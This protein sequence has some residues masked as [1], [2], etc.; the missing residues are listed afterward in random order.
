VW[1]QNIN[2]ESQESW[3]NHL[4]DL[5][6]GL[7]SIHVSINPQEN[8]PLPSAFIYIRNNIIS[9]VVIYLSRDVSEYSIDDYCSS[10]HCHSNFVV[11][12]SG[13]N[14]AHQIDDHGEF[15]NMLSRLLKEQLL[16]RFSFYIT[17]YFKFERCSLS[18]LETSL[19]WL[20]L[21]H[22]LC[23]W[24]QCLGL[25]EVENTKYCTVGT[26]ILSTNRDRGQQCKGHVEVRN[27]S[28]SAT[29]CVIAT[30]IMGIE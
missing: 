13:S 11:P 10:C 22:V 3:Q 24:P 15:A 9:Q 4:W 6:G 5:N 30:W 14:C 23:A 12:T 7:E 16:I 21:W 19:V 29:S 17:S 8:M 26:C 1:L 28:R 27:L 25:V 20:K 18:V 2:L